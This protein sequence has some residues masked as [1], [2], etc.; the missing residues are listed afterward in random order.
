MYKRVETKSEYRKVVE[1]TLQETEILIERFKEISIYK[2]IY[3]QI[4]QIR[5]DVLV[6][7][8]R[9]TLFE[10]V[11]K[12]YLG[13]IAVKNFDVEHDEYAQKLSDISGL[14]YKYLDLPE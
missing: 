4:I 7:K 5:E 1:D 8:L 3:E 6:R 12:Y 11:D 13:A 9:M 14:S 2:V 10:I